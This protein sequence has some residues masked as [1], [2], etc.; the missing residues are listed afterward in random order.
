MQVVLIKDIKTL[1]HAY[2]VVNVK[3]GY[4]RNFLL[5]NGYATVA[6]TALLKKAEKVRSERI[7]KLEEIKENARKMAET[8]QGSVVKLSL[9]ARGEKLYGSI[10]EKDIADALLESQKVEIEKGMVKIKSAIK[11][12]GEHKIKLQLA[13]AV[14][15]EI[16]LIIE[17]IEDKKEDKK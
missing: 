11:T 13:E 2:D 6:T 1:G 15:C 10:H 16:K 9:K 17:G 14:T 12:V 4:A 8:L 7:K 3:P 5:P